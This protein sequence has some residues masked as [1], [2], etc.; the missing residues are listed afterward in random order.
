MGTFSFSPCRDQTF[1]ASANLPE[2]QTNH[3]V[4]FDPVNIHTSRGHPVL[5]VRPGTD[6]KLELV[7]EGVKLLREQAM[8]VAVVVVIGPYR[9]GKSFLLNQLLGVGCAEGFGVGHQRHAETKGIWMWSEP[10]VVQG[11]AIV[12]VDT[13]GFESTGK[14][15][16]YDDRI[17]A[18]STL[19]SSLLIYNLPETVRESDI[20]KLSFAVELAQEFTGRE[21]KHR[22]QMPHLMWLIQRDFLEGR[23]VKDMVDQAMLP[24]K[25]PDHDESVDRLNQ[26]RVALLTAQTNYT[27]FG[28]RQPHLERTKLCD[29]SDDDLDGKYV[30]QREQLRHLVKGL[31]APKHLGGVPLTGG[32]MV[33]FLTRML[34]A[35]NTGNIP[36]VSS[37][38]DTFN[39]KVSEKCVKTFSQGM[40]AF[41]LPS[42]DKILRWHYQKQRTEALRCYRMDAFGRSES[43]HATILKI[44]DE[45]F[46]EM[47]T[48]RF[49]E[50]KLESGKLC[51]QLFLDCQLETDVLT[52]MKL[53]SRA[54]FESYMDSCNTTYMKGCVGPAKEK[55]LKMLQKLR[56]KELRLFLKDYNE[57]LMNGMSLISFGGIMG[58]RFIF[59]SPLCE[60]VGW[61]G[62]ATLELYPKMFLLSSTSMF[63]QGWWQSLSRAWEILVFNKLY[64]LNNVLPQFY[65]CLSVLVLYQK[66]SWFRIVAHFLLHHLCCCCCFKN[67]R[68][69][70]LFE[71]RPLKHPEHIV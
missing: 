39:K 29:L 36:T 18:L 7:S 58:G 37:V 14:T 27:A 10:Q 60:L 57:R 47:L 61:A 1:F 2:K 44:M 6:Q 31:A 33:D 48:Y 70:R 55:Y 52:T 69:A 12:Y 9:S 67:L 56:V 13:E 59:N 46:T 16:V 45:K 32:A 41:S 54:R 34:N 50:N 66:S 19:V 51:E 24:V 65:C 49:Q 22:F 28:L 71:S 15:A 53:P 5:I 25:N 4:Q 63:D 11:H 35:V 17:F 20:A 23:S 30:H 3:G 26:I 38:T 42:D 62:F 64:D 21:Q 43:I 40:K 68:V 8:P